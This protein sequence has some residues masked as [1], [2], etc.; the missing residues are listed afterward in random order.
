MIKQIYSIFQFD[1]PVAVKALNQVE[2]HSVMDLSATNSL[3]RLQGDGEESPLDRYARYK[4]D[5]NEWY[6]DMTKYGLSN[7]EQQCL[8][9][10]LGNSYGMAESQEK[11]ML[12][13]MDKRVSGFSLKQA[14][15]LR[16]AI[17]KK[18]ADVLEETKTLFF[19]SC[20]EQGTRDIFAKYI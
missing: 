4:R 13:S 3:L 20:K 9:E 8:T 17:A 7:S 1:T 6:A 11:V 15:K 12:L 10:H 18:K 14:N 5:I 2:P 19:E 16:K